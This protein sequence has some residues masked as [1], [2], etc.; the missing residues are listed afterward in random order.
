M[1]NVSIVALDSDSGGVA[2]N[3]KVS[4]S[5]S[6]YQL[7]PLAPVLTIPAYE[8]SLYTESMGATS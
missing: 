1:I 4:V 3:Q 2:I 6:G 8:T 7:I 5:V